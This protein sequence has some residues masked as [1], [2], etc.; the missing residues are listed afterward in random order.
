MIGI[1]HQV[2]DSGQG[3]RLWHSVFYSFL[4]L[5]TYTGARLALHSA[6]LVPTLLYCDGTWVLQ[7]KNE[8]KMNAV[9]M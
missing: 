5:P 4:F 9:E 6:V 1:N 8:R 7:N 2:D 3:G